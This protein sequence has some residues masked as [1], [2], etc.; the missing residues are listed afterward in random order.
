MAAFRHDDELCTGAFAVRRTQG[1]TVIAD[2]QRRIE[3]QP[4]RGARHAVD[5]AML[6][7][8]EFAGNERAGERAA[9]LGRD[10][11]HS[12]ERP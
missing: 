7:R 6:D 8:F 9:R 4:A 11:R 1:E 12:N 5:A 3:R 10:T 2:W